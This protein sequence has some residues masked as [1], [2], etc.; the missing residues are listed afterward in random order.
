MENEHQKRKRKYKKYKIREKRDENNDKDDCKRFMIRENRK[1]LK[2]AF[3][4]KIE[5][6]WLHKNKYLSKR[7]ENRKK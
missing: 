5:E 7:D 6:W 4:K 2:Y 3:E 1:K